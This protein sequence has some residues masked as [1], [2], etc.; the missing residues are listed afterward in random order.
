[1]PRYTTL[2]QHVKWHGEYIEPYTA[3]DVSEDDMRLWDELV[4][5]HIAK[6]LTE[7][8][9]PPPEVGKEEPPLKKKST[10][11]K[12]EPPPHAASKA[13]SKGKAK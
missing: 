5:L 1:M 9:E 7:K 6:K 10:P 12:K 4:D 2:D 3:V 11:R 8:E 13:R